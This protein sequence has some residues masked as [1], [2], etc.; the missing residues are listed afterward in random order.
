MVNSPFLDTPG[1]GGYPDFIL[2]YFRP[3]FPGQKKIPSKLQCLI[4]RLDPICFLKKNYCLASI[5]VRRFLG[6]L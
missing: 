4:H 2:S 3:L 5:D 6:Q 1:Y